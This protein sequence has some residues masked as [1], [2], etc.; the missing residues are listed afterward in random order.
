MV[1]DLLKF[2]QGPY[3]V[4]PPLFCNQVQI[5]FG[6]RD[7]VSVRVKIRVLV[8]DVVN[9]DKQTTIVLHNCTNFIYISIADRI[10]QS[11][12]HVQVS[13]KPASGQLNTSNDSPKQ[14][15]DDFL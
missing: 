14:Y 12:N 4:G 13:R 2:G 8:L 7:R 15:G 3:F 1:R 11:F 5:R 10:S 6:V 9:H